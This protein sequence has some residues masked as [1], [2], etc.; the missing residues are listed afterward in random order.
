MVMDVGKAKDR[1][2]ARRNLRQAGERLK[3]G[4]VAEARRL[5]EQVRPPTGARR[6]RNLLKFHFN[7]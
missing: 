2:D 4:D 5:I 7:G 3:Q 6:T 1:R